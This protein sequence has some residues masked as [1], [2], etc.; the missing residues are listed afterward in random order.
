MLGALN[1]NIKGK[2]VEFPD[3]LVVLLKGKYQGGFDIFV[4][5]DEIRPS[6]SCQLNSRM[7]RGKKFTQFLKGTKHGPNIFEVS[8]HSDLLC[9]WPEALIDSFFALG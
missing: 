4:K 9:L 5:N 3:R 6:I 1:K 8:I 2:N 7:T